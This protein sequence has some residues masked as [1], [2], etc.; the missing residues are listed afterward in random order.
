MIS[1]YCSAAFAL[2]PGSKYDML[3][4]IVRVAGYQML[5]W[6]MGSCHM[7]SWCCALL[8][9]SKLILPILASYVRLT[10]DASQSWTSAC[11]YSLS[12]VILADEKFTL[13]HHYLRYCHKGFTFVFS[14]PSAILESN[15][16]LLTWFLP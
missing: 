13:F 15:F 16:T 7:I 6:T 9:L 14:I 1:P 3:A 5:L 2:P 12:N 10:P 11:W 8:G 4:H